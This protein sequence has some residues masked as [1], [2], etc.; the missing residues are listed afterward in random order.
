MADNGHLK[1][2]KFEVNTTVTCNTIH[3]NNL[4]G[5]VDICDPEFGIQPTDTTIIM[6]NN[7][8]MKPAGV[9]DLV[10]MRNKN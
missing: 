3:M 1:N 10:R 8:T 6:Y 7:S 9:I 2:T 4:E 5:I